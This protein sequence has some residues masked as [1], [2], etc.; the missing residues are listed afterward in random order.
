MDNI[1]ATPQNPFLAAIAKQ[2]RAGRDIANQTKFSNLTN[3]IPGVGPMLANSKM[4]ELAFGRSPEG[5]EQMSYGEAPITLP[6]QAKPMGFPKNEE[7]GLRAM[8]QLEALGTMPIAAPAAEAKA[9]GAALSMFLPYIKGDK[10]LKGLQTPVMEKLAQQA[11]EML[12]SGKG[13]SE[14][15]RKTGMWVIP[16]G[17]GRMHVSQLDPLDR[18]FM[19][20]TPDTKFDINPKILDKDGKLPPYDVF[21]LW[22]IMQADNL[23][24]LAPETKDTVVRLNKN[25]YGGGSYNPTTNTIEIG[26]TD[27]VRRAR[28]TLQ[29]EVQ[30]WLQ[31]QNKNNPEMSMPGGGS[32]SIFQG[33]ANNAPLMR[34]LRAVTNEMRVMP[35][36]KDT[37]NVQ[38]V[39]VDTQMGAY[40]PFKAY[41]QLIGEQQAEAAVARR[42]YLPHERLENS[43]YSNYVTNPFSEPGLDPKD[44]VEIIGLSAKGSDSVQSLAQEIVQSLRKTKR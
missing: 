43:P 22:D 44:I 41:Q 6:T 19:I 33:I 15:G 11:I 28:N 30:H 20:E 27:N 23:K 4:G 29:H 18:A 32:P 34:R 3:L 37:K 13:A 5:A 38:Q 40:D 31:Y 9:G 26:D 42:N 16:Q 17:G 1:Q 12:R 10:G 24:R 36:T 8:D 7:G 35:Q 25:Q 2:L 14:T 39:L 21:K